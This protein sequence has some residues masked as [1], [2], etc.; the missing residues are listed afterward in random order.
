MNAVDQH[1]QLNQQA[2][3]ILLIGAGFFVLNEIIRLNYDACDLNDRQDCFVVLIIT[4]PIELG[5]T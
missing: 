1:K 4:H 3:K 5:N 2:Q